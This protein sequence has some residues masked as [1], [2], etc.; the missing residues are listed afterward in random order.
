MTASPLFKLALEILIMIYE[1]LL[2]QEGGMVIPSDPFVRKDEKRTG[3]TPYECKLCQLRFL[4]D[5]GCEQC[6]S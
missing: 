2:I 6:T 5:N 4:S 1:I 3:S